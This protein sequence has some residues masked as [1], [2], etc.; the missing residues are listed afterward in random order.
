[1]VSINSILQKNILCITEC[2]DRR[3]A[4]HSVLFPHCNPSH[5][6]LEY[7]N[8]SVSLAYSGWRFYRLNN[9]NCIS[10][11]GY[12]I[13]MAGFIFRNI[14][15]KSDP[16]FLKKFPYLLLYINT[17]MDLDCNLLSDSHILHTK[18]EDQYQASSCDNCSPGD[19]KYFC[20]FRFFWTKTGL[21]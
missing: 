3:D 8:I 19:I 13:C 12:T 4:A 6:F 14:I 10:Y 2:L 7:Y 9:R 1:M 15:G 21:S 20:A 18:G 17:S 5:R 16:H 11:A